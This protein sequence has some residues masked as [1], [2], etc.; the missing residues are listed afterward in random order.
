MCIR[1]RFQIDPERA[2]SPDRADDA[3]DS[4][5]QLDQPL[6]DDQ[7]D[8]SALD[9]YKRQMHH[10]DAAIAQPAYLASQNAR[11]AMAHAAAKADDARVAA[12]QAERDQIQLAART[13][14]VNNANMATSAALGQRDDAAEQALSLIHI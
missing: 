4:A 2:P 5:H 3:D 1:D 11:L 12:G 13:R 9:V 6:A 7:A 14:D 10:Q 8:S